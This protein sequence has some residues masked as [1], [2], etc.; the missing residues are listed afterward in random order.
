M[1]YLT[2]GPMCSNQILFSFKL[3]MGSTAV[4]GIQDQSPLFSGAPVSRRRLSSRQCQHFGSGLQTN[5][6]EVGV[7]FSLEFQK[8]RNVRIKQTLT[9][10]SIRLT[11]QK[12]KGVPRFVER[13][14]KSYKINQKNGK[15]DLRFT[16][17]KIQLNFVIFN[18]IKTQKKI[19]DHLVSLVFFLFFRGSI[20]CKFFFRPSLFFQFCLSLLVRFFFN[21]FPFLGSVS[22]SK[23]SVSYI[24]P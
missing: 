3:Q 8:L 17:N 15:N 5:R 2:P 10:L 16:M 21:L 4:L 23:N 18:N 7:R 22:F 24:L 1:V 9:N 20:F 13:A 12:L 14:Q 19:L 6:G 11:Q